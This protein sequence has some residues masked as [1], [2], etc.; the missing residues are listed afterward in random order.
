MFTGSGHKARPKLIKK[1]GVHMTEVLGR[2]AWCLTGLEGRQGAWE[3]VW[4]GGTSTH[5]V[6]GPVNIETSWSLCPSGKFLWT[7]N[8][9]AL[10]SVIVHFLST[11]LGHGVRRCLVQ[12]YSAQGVSAKVFLDESII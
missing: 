9:I 5:W 1:R 7:G 6:P 4:K 12:H 11:R 8:L 3:G 2:K 10:G